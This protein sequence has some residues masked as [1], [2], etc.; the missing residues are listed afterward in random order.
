MKKVKFSIPYNGDI[1][2]IKWAI[3]NKQVE[4]VYFAG[5]Q[6]YD[7]SDPYENEKKHSLYDVSALMRLCN[8]NKVDTNLL[9]NKNV[10]FFE[11][12]ARIKKSINILQKAGSL[13]YITVA[14]VFLAKWL[15]ENFPLIKL[16][17]SIYMG[18]NNFLKVK[19]GIKAGISKFCLDPSINRNG[20]EL[21]KIAGLKK[22][23]PFLRI[24]LLG[25]IMCYQNCFYS[26]RHSALPIFS[27]QIKSKGGYLGE[28]FDCYK[29]HY[30]PS[31]IVD[32][33]KRPY[34]RPEDVS[35]YEKEK[36]TDSIK[37]AY[38]NEPSASLKLKMISY[39]N[40]SYNGNLFDLMDS[41]NY[42]NLFCDNKR[43]PKDFAKKVVE[44]NKDCF[45]CGY[46]EFIA[47]R[48]LKAR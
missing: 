3:K 29:C 14:D 24:K 4:E 41:I 13:D 10:M 15:K 46:C 22:H 19:E 42:D 48:Y 40:R 39:F 31:G 45:S 30:L 37:L 32:E 21:R 36:L 11:S 26:L 5:P 17:S 12:L 20:Q 25:L 16:Q 6:G 35:Y 44:C 2:L 33:I 8:K 28:Q 23:Y 7:F 43:I 18:I 47:K 34:V 1:E 27:R 9:I 38:R